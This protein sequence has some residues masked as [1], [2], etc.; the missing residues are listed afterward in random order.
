ARGTA[1]SCARLLPPA[2]AKTAAHA[3]A[4]RG[5]VAARVELQPASLVPGDP[6]PV[7]EDRSH[8]AGVRRARVRRISRDRARVPVRPVR[9][10]ERNPRR[11]VL[12]RRLLGDAPSAVEDATGG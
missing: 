12:W 7:R 1:R 10:P 3:Y 5:A 6:S 8:H 9:A 11:Q 2:R 4:D